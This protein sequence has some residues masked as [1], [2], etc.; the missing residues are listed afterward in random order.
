[1]SSALYYA[2][3]GENDKKSYRHTHTAKH[4]TTKAHQ[5][6]QEKILN[7]REEQA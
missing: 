4:T 3:Y 2:Y 6:V 7:Y 1:M 5:L